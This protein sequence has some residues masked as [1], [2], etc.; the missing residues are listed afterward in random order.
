MQGP[1]LNPSLTTEPPAA[2]PAADT[3]RSAETLPDPSVPRT[4]EAT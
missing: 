4:R 3:A 1:Q 2:D